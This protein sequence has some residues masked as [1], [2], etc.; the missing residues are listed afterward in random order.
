M[1]AKVSGL[2][3]PPVVWWPDARTMTWPKAV[4]PTGCNRPTR[5]RIACLRVAGADQQR[6]GEGWFRP[7]SPERARATDERVARQGPRRGGTA[8][9][10]SASWLSARAH[11]TYRY[12]PCSREYQQLFRGSRVA[13]A[14][15]SIWWGK[16][17]FGARCRLLRQQHRQG[18][19]IHWFCGYS[20]RGCISIL[21]GGAG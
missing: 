15:G 8:C 19:G 6:K 11:H 7:T 9:S 17:L 16:L 2:A 3:V 1:V 10:R 13:L 12:S 14:G 20:C 18:V 4:T 5:S 21:A